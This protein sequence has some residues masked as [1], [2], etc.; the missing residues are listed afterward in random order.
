MMADWRRRR[1]GTRQADA[2]LPFEMISVAAARMVIAEVIEPLA[3]DMRTI[4]AGAWA[5]PLS[6]EHRALLDIQPFKGGT[7]DLRYGISCSWVPHREGSRWRWH[8][9]LRQSRHDLWV[10]HFTVDAPPPHPISHHHGLDHLRRQADE[11]AAEVIPLAR[12]WW[13]SVA[14]VPA[15]LTEARRQ[16]GNGS[17]PS[18]HWPHPTLV[19]AFTLCRLGDPAT[20]EQ[21]LK[22]TGH[23]S[24]SDLAAAL[25][26]LAE[27]ARTTS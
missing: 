8:R 20:A 16:E 13:D 15:V 27:L 2:A 10:D 6:D 24:E 21:H 14:A 18:L 23:L 17:A 19:T 3:R 7:V 26:R 22:I 25:E 11:A 4:R 5:R 12:H 1:R 9:T